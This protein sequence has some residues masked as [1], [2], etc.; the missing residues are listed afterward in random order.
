MILFNI[1]SI[2]I[3][4]NRYSL[5]LDFIGGRWKGA[6]LE[7]SLEEMEKAWDEE[8]RERFLDSRAPRGLSEV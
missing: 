5:S 2:I 7:M 6:Y 8:K 3:N 4:P 1:T